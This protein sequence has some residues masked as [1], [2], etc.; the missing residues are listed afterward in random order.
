M[1]S[2]HI[3]LVRTEGYITQSRS[4]ILSLCVLLSRFQYIYVIFFILQF[5]DPHCHNLYNI[6]HLI[7]K[8]FLVSSSVLD[9]VTTRQHGKYII[10]INTHKSWNCLFFPSCNHHTLVVIYS[11]TSVDGWYQTHILESF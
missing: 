1:F 3:P 10:E 8:S 6:C 9:L 4:I 2:Q 11:A 5:L 7:F